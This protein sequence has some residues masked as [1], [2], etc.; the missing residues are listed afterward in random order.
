MH[1][2]S[3]GKGV[4]VGFC[5]IFPEF[6]ILD[7]SYSTIHIYHSPPKCDLRKS[8][9]LRSTCFKKLASGEEVFFVNLESRIFKLNYLFF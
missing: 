2:I 4:G 6:L 3:S 9:R 1:K 8:L 5:E 7:G